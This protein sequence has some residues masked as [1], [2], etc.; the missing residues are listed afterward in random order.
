MPR[1]SRYQ[2]AF[3]PSLD[4]L[5]AAQIFGA[6]EDLRLKA[7]FPNDE[8]SVAEIESY[9]ARARATVS[10]ESWEA[11]LSNGRGLSQGEIITLLRTDRDGQSSAAS[12]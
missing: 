4:A 1:R 9:L 7:S 6:A 12:T 2:R 5:R 11:A 8:R 3:L 10:S